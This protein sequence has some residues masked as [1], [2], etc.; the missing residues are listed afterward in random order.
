MSASKATAANRFGLGA[1]PGEIDRGSDGREVLLA[2]LQQPASLSEF[3]GLPG[4]AATMRSEF[5]QQ[6]INR[7]N[8]RDAAPATPPPASA[9]QAAAA[10]MAA[11]DMAAPNLS[12]APPRRRRAN[13]AAATMPGDNKPNA[14]ASDADNP[15]Q[16]M[17]RDLRRQQLN[18]FAARYRH[19][20][21]TQAPFVERLTQF[22]SNH[23]AVSIDKSNARL[24]AA[25]MEREAIR[26]HVTGRFEDMLFAVETHPAM[27]RYLDNAV[28]IGNDSRVAMNAERANKPKRG[29]NENLAREILELHTLGVNGGYKQADVTE[30]AR[31]ITGW[32]TPAPRDTDIDNPF[33]FRA[34]AHEPGARRVLGRDY[35]EGGLDQGRA[36]LADLAR[37]PATAKHLSF[38]LA[39]HF[40]ADEP[41][42]ALVDAMAKA[43]LRSGGDLRALYT[44][45]VESQLAWA[46]DARKF[47]T[48]NDF[49]I[50]A[51][52]AGELPVDD[53]ARALIALLASLGQ[54]VFTP[55]SPAGFPDTTA[56]W[57]S[58]D[59]LF[60]RI[61]AAQ[62]FAARVDATN[63]ITP[64]QRAVSV[65]G[66]EAVSGDF[67]IGLRRAGS[68]SD[69]YSLLF[70]SPAFQWRA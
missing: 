16:A 26:P 36:V 58:P 62:L 60:K 67:A 30:L 43:Y 8:R 22:W 39:R 32:S 50:S 38:K 33:V 2:Q 55:R 5:E 56:D 4:S 57:S 12:A 54:P 64:Y 27:L 45:L 61:Q 14:A 20:A 47:K 41:P 66:S 10:D 69:G 11:G 21:R 70:A 68:A 63:G 15:G 42:P 28:S 53:D 51:L 46:P 35:A 3:E 1:R 18:E 24:Y 48:P 31:A 6:R 29:L 34:N 7:E 40:V 59:G 13:A 49:V 9:A 65:L 25:S 23:F 52:R 17:L 19:A 37:H 44:A